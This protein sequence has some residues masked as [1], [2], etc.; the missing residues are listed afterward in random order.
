MLG[1]GS[2]NDTFLERPPS[3]TLYV[4]FRGSENFQ[5]WFSN[6][7][8]AT[9]T[10]KEAA[11]QDPASIYGERECYLERGEDEDYYSEDEGSSPLECEDESSEECEEEGAMEQTECSSG[12]GFLDPDADGEND[13]IV[14]PINPP[15]ENQPLRYHK[16]FLRRALGAAKA[17]HDVLTQEKGIRRIVLTGHSSGAAQAAILGSLV[18]R[19]VLAKTA[20]RQN[21]LNALEDVSVAGFSTPAT[22]IP[23]VDHQ[24][25][26][27]RQPILRAKARAKRGAVESPAYKSFLQ[28]MVAKAGLTVRN[29]K[30]FIVGSDIVPRLGAIAFEMI[31]DG[32][33]GL[34]V[35][36]MNN[37]HEMVENVQEYLDEALGD[38]GGIG[39]L[40]LDVLLRLVQIG[41]VSHMIHPAG[42]Y[43]LLSP[44]DA[45]SS[46]TFPVD[47]LFAV[48][49]LVAERLEEDSE[50]LPALQGAIKRKMMR[51]VIK[52]GLE[53]AQPV[54]T[55]GV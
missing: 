47:L 42:E 32:S 2:M 54:R 41:K 26:V 3:D 7:D 20:L 55:L 40:D 19:G 14:S 49:Q 43:I 31:K 21:R 36:K 53:R 44:T 23:G 1:P 13:L 11:F 15:Y 18:A 22:L 50:N 17:L 27:E 16:G 10:F 12:E 38:L 8:F 25:G 51:E 6:F 46:Y 39:E 9:E 4:V 29:N 48:M 24:L 35:E 30:N 45:R 37:A 34:V 5:D 28:R 52:M 33:G